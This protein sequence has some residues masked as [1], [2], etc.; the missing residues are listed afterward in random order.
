MQDKSDDFFGWKS[1]DRIRREMAQSGS[2]RREEAPSESG[3]S[4]HDC[5]R[6]GQPSVVLSTKEGN[7]SLINGQPGASEAPAAEPA[8]ASPART[9]APIQ[10]SNIPSFHHSITSVPVGPLPPA[11]EPAT[12]NMHPATSSSSIHG[13]NTPSFH[14]SITPV[15]AERCL[16]C[17]TL[18]PPLLSSGER[19]TPHCKKCGTALRAPGALIEFCPKCRH[20]IQE[21]NDN[22]TRPT[23]NCRHCNKP[24]PPPP[25]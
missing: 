1:A 9:D 11:G 15:P 13:S 25:S 12:W 19:P 8:M 5:R 4:E 14:P 21:L 22:G 2:S 6:R 23:P 24:L 20:V 16:E 18:L 10:G 3:K 17:G 7:E